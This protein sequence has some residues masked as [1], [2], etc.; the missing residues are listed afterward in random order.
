VELLYP[1]PRF[2][3]TRRSSPPVCHLT[4]DLRF[5]AGGRD[6]G[7]SAALKGAL[8]AHGAR[9]GITPIQQAAMQRIPA[10]L[11]I[12]RATLPHDPD[13]CRRA[14]ERGYETLTPRPNRCQ[15]RLHWRD[16][17]L[18][19]SSA[20]RVRQ[21]T[22]GFGLSLRYIARRRAVLKKPETALALRH[23]AHTRTWLAGFKTPSSALLYAKLAPAAH[24]LLAS[25]GMDMSRRRG[26]RWETCGAHIVCATPGRLVDQ[27]S[28]DAPHR[29]GLVFARGAGR[30]DRE[31]SNSGF[32]EDLEF[33]L[34]SSGLRQAHAHV[35]RPRLS[36]ALS[37]GLTKHIMKQPRSG[38]RRSRRKGQHADT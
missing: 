13:P 38:L 23:R 1:S 22:V 21:G 14:S 12:L 28:I 25:G 2:R 26:A 37:R 16:R 34:M 5:R 18:L 9:P 24:W 8:V 20:N 6:G 35:F 30:G 10:P 4:H 31:C 32:R 3:P 29:P 7:K 17:D 33:I 15:R 27:Q 19:V 36:C 11:P